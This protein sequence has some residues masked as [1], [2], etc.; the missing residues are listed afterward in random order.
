MMQLATVIDNH[1]NYGIYARDF[2]IVGPTRQNAGTHYYVYH[3]NKHP[4]GKPVAEGVL[5][6]KGCLPVELFKI[7]GE[8]EVN[9]PEESPLTEVV[10][11]NLFD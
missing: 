9:E 5:R 7:V 1:P 2:F 11:M 6:F 10:Q 3:Q 8:L 4:F